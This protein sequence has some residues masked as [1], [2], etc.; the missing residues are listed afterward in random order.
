MVDRFQPKAIFD[1]IAAGADDDTDRDLLLDERGLGGQPSREELQRYLNAGVDTGE[2][3]SA[4]D[5]WKRRK[6]DYPLVAKLAQK[7]LS[8]LPAAAIVERLFSYMGLYTTKNRGRL[9]N[10]NVARMAFLKGQQIFGNKCNES[11]QSTMLVALPDKA[12][13][14]TVS[15]SVVGAQA[16][17]GS[18]SQKKRKQP[19]GNSES[20]EM[21]NRKRS[22]TPSDLTVAASTKR[23]SRNQ[24]QSSRK[25]Q[26]TERRT[27]AASHQSESEDSDNPEDAVECLSVRIAPGSHADFDDFSDLLN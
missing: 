17:M 19:R 25:T 1:A 26:R 16:T 10:V 27:D 6:D 18:R 15:S 20:H 5:A 9:S 2:K 23:P 24:N 22:N 4:W 3:L 11:D 14:V 13:T 21:S 8:V 12:G 7:Y